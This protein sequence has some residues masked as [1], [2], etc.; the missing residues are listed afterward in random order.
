M[1]TAQ[2][3][4]EFKD[5]LKQAGYVDITC[6]V[7]QPLKFNPYLF[8]ICDYIVLAF[9]PLTK[10]HLLSIVDF[11]YGYKKVSVKDNLQLY[12]YGYLAAKRVADDEEEINKIEFKFRIIQ[13]RINHDETIELNATELTNSIAGCIQ[14]ANFLNERNGNV[15]TNFSPGN[16]CTWCPGIGKCTAHHDYQLTN[17]LALIG[18]LPTPSKKE[19]KDKAAELSTTQQIQLFKNIPLIKELMDAVTNQL[20]VQAM[21]GVEL[22]GVKLIRGVSK[23]KWVSDEKLVAKKLKALGIDKP[24]VTK[25][26][27]LNITDVEKR[28]GKGQIDSITHTPTPKVILVDDSEPGEQYYPKQEL[29][30]LI[31][32]I[33]E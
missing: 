14:L 15:P 28:V 29:L 17:N 5:D 6:W 7:E 30:N 1:E 24:F 4:K 18:K 23:R 25:K 19:I 13:P 9:N 27:L 3:L 31:T 10:K 26:S 33:G 21:N 16:H 32:E 20:Y 22:P 11:K 12:L 2:K 8:G